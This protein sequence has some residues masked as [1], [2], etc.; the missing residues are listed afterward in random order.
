MMLESRW[1][2]MLGRLA[3]LAVLASSTALASCGGKATW[4][5]GGC[6]R[7]DLTVHLM[8]RKSVD[9]VRIAPDHV[10]LEGNT[11]IDA[12]NLLRRRYLQE[13]FSYQPIEPEPCA[14]NPRPRPDACF[15]L[16][17]PSV[18]LEDAKR[19]ADEL[20]QVP[21]VETVRTSYDTRC[22]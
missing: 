17:F 2:V 9:G 12:V 19:L 22:E 7:N 18:V 11:A 15:A 13:S 6:E 8:L 14:P 10:A 5:P 3:V 16:H 21:A 4:S 1:I 20:R